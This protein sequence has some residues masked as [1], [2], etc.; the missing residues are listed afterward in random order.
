MADVIQRDYQRYQGRGLLGQCA[1]PNVPHAYHTGKIHV[2]AGGTAP[3]PGF[4]VWYDQSENAYRLP[5][6]DAQERQVI[7]IL[8][9][10]QG[11]NVRQSSYIGNTNQVLQY[12]DDDVV[13]VA[14]MGAFFAKAGEAM[15]YGDL[16][17]FDRTAA[18]LD[19]KKIDSIS[20]AATPTTG[21]VAS[22]TGFANAYSAANAKAVVDAVVAALA[23]ILKNQQYVNVVCLDQTVASGDMFIAGVATGRSI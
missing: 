22:A 3:K 15:E 18:E 6:T 5:T 9:Y 17:Y 13:K 23:T 4:G 1:R 14:V 8:S 11:I 19:W 10:E 21:A 2:P 16:V 12:S 7:G 20:E